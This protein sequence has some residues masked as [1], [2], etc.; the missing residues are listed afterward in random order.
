MVDMIVNC[1]GDGGVRR[2]FGV[3]DWLVCVR[4]DLVIGGM[5]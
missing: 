3:V 1:R 2:V 4:S 5:K